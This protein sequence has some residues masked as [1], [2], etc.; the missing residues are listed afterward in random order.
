MSTNVK[1]VSDFKC[2]NGEVA[3]TNVTIQSMT[4]KKPKYPTFSAAAVCEG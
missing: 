2:H 1:V 3:F 4:D